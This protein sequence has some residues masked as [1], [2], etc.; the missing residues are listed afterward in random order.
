MAALDPPRY[1]KQW[2]DGLAERTALYALRNI[3]TGDT[4]DLAQDFTVVKRAVLLGTTVAG[5]VAA[6]ASANTIITIP[7]GVSAD[8][9]YLLAF[10]V[11]A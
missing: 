3:T 7:A 9:G 6:V 11:A 4:V 5:A 8:A 2:Q 10:G 1:P